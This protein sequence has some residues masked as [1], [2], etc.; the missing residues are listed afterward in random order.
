M[1]EP[2]PMTDPEGLIW[3][4]V[5]RSI[6]EALDQIGIDLQ[7]WLEYSTAAAEVDIF[8][9][10]RGIVPDAERKLSTAERRLLALRE[11][12]PEVPESV[13]SKLSAASTFL[14]MHKSDPRHA[15]S[16]RESILLQAA[17]AKAAVTL[18]RVEYQRIKTEQAQRKFAGRSGADAKHS[19][20]RSI[21]EW[22][23]KHAKSSSKDEARRLCNSMPSEIKKLSESF[24]D[25]ERLIY[26]AIR[27]SKNQ[28]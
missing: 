15:G 10:G 5:E 19:P 26:D 16:P 7:V 17:E 28:G 25:P 6:L 11:L 1:N 9:Q 18:A 20:A 2:L 21:G 3:D 27:K 24:K 8:R 4:E 13:I 23:V 22:A 12:T 14:S